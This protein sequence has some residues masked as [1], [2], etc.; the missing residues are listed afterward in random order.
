M[1]TRRGPDE[2]V[3][4][5]ISGDYAGTK[6]TNVFW[7]H[8][9]HTTA[10]D[11]ATMNTFCGNLYDIYKVGF[12]PLMSED[13]TLQ[14]CS[15]TYFPTGSPLVVVGDHTGSDAGGDTGGDNLP[16]SVAAVVS[17]QAGVYWRGGKPR[18]YIG[19][20]KADTLNDVKTLDPTFVTNLVSDGV[21]WISACNALASGN[22]DSVQFGLVS[23]VSGG[24]DRSPP[25][26]FPIVGATVHSRIDS[27][28]RR[29]G[30]S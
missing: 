5:A 15:A 21:N 12:L 9:T 19:G 29:L 16:A 1:A 22:F 6:W 26:F 17:W 14:E 4:A 7:F 10:V 11:A 20:L 3:R 30:K 28:R 2:S 27:Q 24:V 23:F 8:T 25:L 18:T 13:S